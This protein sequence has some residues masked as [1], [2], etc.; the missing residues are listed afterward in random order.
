MPRTQSKKFLDGDCPSG[1]LAIYDNGGKTW[2]R[3]TVF[4]KPV[5][6]LKDRGEYIGYRGMSEDPYSPQG[7]GIYGEMKAWE[8]AAYR[9]R[10]Y[11]DSAKWSDLPEQVKKS[12][13][14]DCSDLEVAAAG[15][16]VAPDAEL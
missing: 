2:D 13:R 12:V 10:V 6:V 5:D 11:R 16:D 7:F 14:Q 8:V 4:Y 3:Y 9:E 15:Y 1:V